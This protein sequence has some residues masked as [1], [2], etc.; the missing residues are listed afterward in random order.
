MLNSTVSVNKFQ[1]IAIVE[2]DR[3]QWINQEAKDRT[4]MRAFIDA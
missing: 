4:I 3:L 1:R 2:Y